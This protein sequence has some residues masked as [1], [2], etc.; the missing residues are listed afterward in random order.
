MSTSEVEAIA[1]DVGG[2]LSSLLKSTVIDVAAPRVPDACS[3]VSKLPGFYHLSTITG[4][5]EG[6]EIA[7]Y[8]HFWKGTGFVVVRTL[9]RKSE[10][11]V[12][13]VA[14]ILPAATLYEAEIQ[15]L[16]GV[17]FEGSP[18]TGKRLLLPD[19]YP[20]DAPPPLR[21]EADPE[22]IRKMMKLE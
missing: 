5:D 14:G 3:A 13:S 9:V 22:K 20:A 21:T 1:R 16:L 6:D 10:P 7:L 18:Y 17:T 4:V 12:P 15:D 2:R 19:D 8:Y 11:K